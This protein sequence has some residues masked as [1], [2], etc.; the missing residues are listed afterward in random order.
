MTSSLT[1]RTLDRPFPSAQAEE[2]G[3]AQTCR[4]HD[5]DKAKNKITPHIQFSC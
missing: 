3:K 2:A 4:K 5:E 1:R